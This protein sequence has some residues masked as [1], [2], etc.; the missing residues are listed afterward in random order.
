MFIRHFLFH[1]HV[2]E[3]NVICL[4]FQMIFEFFISQLRGL[5]DPK[6]AAFKR[7]FY[8]LENLAWVKSFNICIELETSNSVF[9]QL[10]TLMF[11]MIK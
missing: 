1:L 9:C 2:S 6:D 7:Y 4:S 5:E 11:N 3:A 10:Y 8:L